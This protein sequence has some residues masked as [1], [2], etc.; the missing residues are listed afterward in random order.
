MLQQQRLK[1][2]GGV[3]GAL[4][5][6]N[7]LLQ[8]RPNTSWGAEGSLA[9]R[10]P[11]VL[12]LQWGRG[13]KVQQQL[14]GSSRE[15]REV[16]RTRSCR[17]KGKVARQNPAD[18]VVQTAP[19]EDKSKGLSTAAVGQESPLSFGKPVKNGSAELWLSEGQE[20]R[21]GTATVCQ[22]SVRSLHVRVLVRVCCWSPHCTTNGAGRKRRKAGRK[23]RST[24]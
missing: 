18:R 5:L 9:A 15:C 16:C 24:R 11:Q 20:G 3:F 22:R 12:L 14:R 7:P 1:G 23:G 13:N 19:A 17:L 2:R 4:K 21:E 6:Q 8:P 10:I